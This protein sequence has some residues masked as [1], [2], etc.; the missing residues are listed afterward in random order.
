MKRRGFLGFLAGGAVAGPSMVKQAATATMTDMSLPGIAI[1]GM[2]AMASIPSGAYPGDYQEDWV[3]RMAKVALRS[4]AEHQ[5]RQRQ[6]YIS[7]LDPD[8]VTYRSFA[9]H[10]KIAVQKKRDYWRSIENEKSWLQR[11]IDGIM[12]W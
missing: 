2:G 8:L 12:D 11:R 10:A 6:Q 5:E 9:L 1:N 7:G 3:G 4:K